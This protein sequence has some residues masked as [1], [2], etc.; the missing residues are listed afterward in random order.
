MICSGCRRRRCTGSRVAS[1][2]ARVPGWI[3]GGK[4]AA[5]SE[6]AIQAS[7]PVTMRQFGE[8]RAIVAVL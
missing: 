3:T 5:S 8:E 6:A 1:A 2:V 4:S 7:E